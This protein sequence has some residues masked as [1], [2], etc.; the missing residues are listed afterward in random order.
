MPV[1]QAAVA[2]V[3]GVEH[4]DVVALLWWAA[5]G[6]PELDLRGADFLRIG[7]QA[8]PVKRGGGTGHDKVV[9]HAACAKAAMPESAHFHGAIDQL[10]VV[11]GAILETDVL[12]LLTEQTK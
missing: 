8:F 4:E 1:L 2:V 10:I 6:V 5:V 11:L 3:G 7:Q 9:L 12:D